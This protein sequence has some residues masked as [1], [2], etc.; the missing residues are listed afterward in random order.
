MLPLSLGTLIQRT[1][2][3][4]VKG[5]VRWKQLGMLRDVVDGAEDDGECQDLLSDTLSGH[6]GERGLCHLKNVKLSLHVP[7]N[8]CA[9]PCSPSSCRSLLMQDE[10]RFTLGQHHGGSAN[11]RRAEAAE[12]GGELSVPEAAGQFGLQV[13]HLPPGSGK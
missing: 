9:L 6:T 2:E 12:R 10:P 5:L 7:D 11:S 8:L 13:L 3:L 4:S 1:S